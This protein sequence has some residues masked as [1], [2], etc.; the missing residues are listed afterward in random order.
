MLNRGT[1][2]CPDTLWALAAV[3]G[4]LYGV[5][6][7]ALWLVLG[8]CLPNSGF[9]LAAYP[10]AGLALLVTSLLSAEPSAGA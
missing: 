5:A 10:L 6:G 8:V 4:L 1:G 7:A 2:L 9:A 3:A